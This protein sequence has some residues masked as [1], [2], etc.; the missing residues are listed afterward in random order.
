M[1]IEAEENNEENVEID[2]QALANADE[3]IMEDE[4]NELPELSATEQK[5]F[6]QGWRPLDEFNGDEDNWKTAKEYVRDGE[7]LATIKEQNQ[8]ME[9]MN[10]EFNSRLENTNKLH[11]AR[12]KQEIKDLETEMRDAVKTSDSDAYDAAKDKIT[13]LEKETVADKPVVEQ[14]VDPV[15]A[16]WEA[17]NP[18]IN[19]ESD[20]KRPIAQGIWRDYVSKNKGATNEQALAYVDKEMSELFPSNNE[21]PRRNGQNTTETP[22]KRG[23]R[24]T[25]TLSVS[26]LTAAEKS[27]LT[28]F[29]H[30]FKDEQ[31][32]LKAAQ[33]A[34]K[35]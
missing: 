19:D 5:A 27:D 31:A 25:K 30:M 4:K 11:E 21:N 2:L 18:W 12:R 26:D 3:S 14:N 17:K 9:R 32:F 7:F 8:K 33:D 15:I 35:A 6:D 28:N 22:A 24:G 34:R 20:R 13:E 23:K 1:G 29:G 10:S 16:A